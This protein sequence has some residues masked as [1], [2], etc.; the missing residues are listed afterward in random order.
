MIDLIMDMKFCYFDNA[1]SSIPDSRVLEF[2]RNF[3]AGEF[4]NQE[5]AHGGGYALRK[6]L[7]KASEE[8]SVALCGGKR[9]VIWGNSGSELFNL[10]ADSPLVAGQDVSASALEHP[11]LAANLKRTAKSVT[12]LPNDRAGKVQ[13]PDTGVLAL[14]HVQSELG[15]IQEFPERK[16][17][18]FCDAIQSA[19]KLSLPRSPEIIAVSGHKF[20]S[21][22]GAALLLRPDWK[23][24]KKLQEFAHV[25]R[26]T[27]YRCGRPEVP[28]LLAMT[29]AAKLRAAER[30]ENLRH[31]R[32][33]NALL[34]EHF[35][36]TLPAETAS[37]YILHLNFPGYQ[38]GVLVRMLSD[39]GFMVS[40][41]SACASETDEPSPAMR[42]IGFSRKEAFSG[43]RISFGPQ[44]TIKEAKNLL[45]VLT[46]VL[47]NY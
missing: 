4:A 30:E 33:L 8:L 38:S 6:R 36:A 23:E 16:G 27:L 26:H 44:N 25:Y 17:V 28:L 31:V 14:H 34:R 18:T 43:L 24:A 9:L 46:R 29:E 11:A 19:G 13:I 2:Y 32:E 45:E 15:T 12:I 3:S 21:P 39:A 47:K 35:N 5:A 20:G 41:G 10:L 7:E 42:T 37:P 40:A 22:G 1:A